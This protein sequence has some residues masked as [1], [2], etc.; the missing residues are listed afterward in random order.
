MSTVVAL[1]TPR[2]RGALAVIRLSGPE[3]LAI[4]QQLARVDSFAPRHATLTKLWAT[5]EMLDQVLLTTFPAPRSLTGEDVVEISCHG[6]PAIV[7][8]IVDATLA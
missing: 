2:G 7:R 4:V 3:A 6:S 8:R 5:D 1:S